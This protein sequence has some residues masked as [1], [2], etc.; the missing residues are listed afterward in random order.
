MAHTNTYCSLC[1]RMCA[2][3]HLSLPTAV[4][5]RLGYPKFFLP[6]LCQPCQPSPRVSWKSWWLRCSFSL[7]QETNQQ[8]YFS[9]SGFHKPGIF[10][11]LSTRNLLWPVAFLQD[12]GLEVTLGAPSAGHHPPLLVGSCRGEGVHL[13]QNGVCNQTGDGGGGE[14]SRRVAER[15]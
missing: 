13:F 10:L 8:F 4:E 7:T 15:G 1:P 9:K 2:H 3:P 11:F 6:A 5:P 12:L 14:P